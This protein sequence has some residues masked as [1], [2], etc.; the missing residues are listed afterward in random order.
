[1][2]SATTA[3]YEAGSAIVH[4][5]KIPIKVSAGESFIDSLRKSISSVEKNAKSIYDSKQAEAISAI[6]IV[7]VTIFISS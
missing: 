4:E 6:V 5:K 1:M 3:N 2:S 7:C